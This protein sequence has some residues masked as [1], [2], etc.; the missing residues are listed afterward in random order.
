[1]PIII[2]LS[3]RKGGGK[4]TIS[5]FLLENA[6]A[7]WPQPPRKVSGDL[8]TPRTDARLYSFAGPVKRFCVDVMGLSEAQ[9]YGSDEDKNSL[10]RY[11]WEDMPHYPRIVERIRQQVLAEHAALPWWYR[12]GE[13]LVGHTQKNVEAEVDRRAPKGPMT[14]RQV[15]QEVGTGIGRQMHGEIWTEAC[16]RQILSESPDVA[17]IDDVRF[18]NEVDIVEKNGGVVLRLH[19][20]P[21]RGDE[22]VS[23]TALDGCEDF[24]ADV[25][26]DLLDVRGSCLAVVEALKNLGVT[27]AIDRL[28]YLV[29]EAPVLAPEVA[30]V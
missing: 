10:T 22:H 13:A 9:C 6:D 23:E 4:S 29:G 25:R 16:L 30:A 28:G 7:L 14:A 1:M 2:G 20:A 24:S 21:H 11:R 19:R 15:M 26:N 17:L 12:W 27:D 3:A 18:P 8:I 5:R